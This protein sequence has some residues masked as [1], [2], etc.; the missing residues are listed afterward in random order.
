[1]I[2]EAI[3]SDCKNLTALS[4]L[5][6]LETYA[7]EGIKTEYSDF[8]LSTFTEKYFSDLLSNAN[9]RI[10][11]HQKRNVQIQNLHIVL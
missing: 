4:L 6:W 10:L 2:R 11:I 9:Y 8:A 5:V 3:Q 7:V 1:M